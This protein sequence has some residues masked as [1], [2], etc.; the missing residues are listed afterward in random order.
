VVTELTAGIAGS[1]FFLTQSTV[2]YLCV[3]GMALRVAANAK[4]APAPVQPLLQRRGFYRPVL[5]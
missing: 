4:Y 1:S 3:W 2:P 5:R